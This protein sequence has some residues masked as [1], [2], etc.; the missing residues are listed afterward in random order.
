MRRLNLLSFIVVS[1]GLGLTSCTAHEPAPATP[2]AERSSRLDT[3]LSLSQVEE[4]AMWKDYKV[5]FPAEATA[6]MAHQGPHFT[7]A[8]DSYWTYDT[9]GTATAA[10]SY[11]SSNA[12]ASFTIVAEAY[13]WAEQLWRKWGAPQRC[14]PHFVSTD[15]QSQGWGPYTIGWAYVPCNWTWPYYAIH[16][17]TQFIAS[18]HRASTSTIVN[19]HGTNMSRRAVVQTQLCVLIAHEMGHNHGLGHGTGI[20][21]PNINEIPPPGECVSWGIRSAA[22]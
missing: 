9:G 3:Y 12:E 13:Y 4:D 8:S 6:S 18:A 17:D 1:A 11:S 20:M 22:R 19:Y 15:V 7:E 5:Q 14:R 10:S 2:V 16:L 21:H